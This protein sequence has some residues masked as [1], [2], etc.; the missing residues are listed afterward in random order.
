MT[1]FRTASIPRC[2]FAKF[3]LEKMYLSRMIFLSYFYEHD[4]CAVT[5]VICRLGSFAVRS[6]R[7]CT[8]YGHAPT[9]YQL[10]SRVYD[11]MFVSLF[12]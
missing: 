8:V 11:G 9:M 10:W 5:S 3:D 6:K 7:L 4:R 1:M 12:K 2:L